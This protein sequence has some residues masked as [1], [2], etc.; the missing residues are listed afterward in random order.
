MGSGTFRRYY[1]PDVASPMPH[2]QPCFGIYAHPWALDDHGVEA[3][4]DELAQVGFD[5]LQLALS[6][7]VAA[8]VTPRNPRRR[9]FA[10]DAGSVNVRLNLA[11]DSMWAL[12]PSINERAAM[13]VPNILRAASD[14][15]IRVIA[16]L[17][18]LYSHDLASRYPDAAV[19]NAFGDRHP[20]QLCPSNPL[21]RDYALA[22]TAAVVNLGSTWDSCAGLHAESLSFLP[23]DYGLL[24]LKMAVGPSARAQRELSLCFCAACRT[25]AE[26]EGLD[27]DST[28]RAVKLRLADLDYTRPELSGAD[29]T[30]ERYSRA[31][32]ESTVELTKEVQTM[33][34]QAGLMFSSTAAEA[35]GRRTDDDAVPQLRELV[36]EMRVKV[37][38]DA[39]P[40]AVSTAVTAVLTG[41]RPDTRVFAQ[42]QV[43][44]FDTSD[45]LVRA[46]A[47]SEEAGVHEHRFYEHSVLTEEHLE[48]LRRARETLR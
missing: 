1:I 36:Q 27:A 4:M 29:E 41:C 47:A 14:R 16:W 48:W 22:L 42:Y 9:V 38:P 37:L 7:H 46:V 6:Y 39:S 32:S 26:I 12:R 5:T 28:A 3:A 23:W 40:E 34:A 31:L 17:V 2:R 30:L 10:G 20:A 18:Y 24:G 44:L 11:S 43:H 8:F 33:A 35:A 45:D 25:R 15:G 13:A 19:R 21:V